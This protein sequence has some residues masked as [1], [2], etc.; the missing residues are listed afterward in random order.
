[1]LIVRAAREL[2]TANGYGAVTI[3]RVADAAGMTPMTLYS[4]FDAK[5]DLLRNLWS[6][7]FGNLFDTLDDV[8]DREPDAQTRLRKVSNGYVRFWVDH[9]DHYRM[10]FM[11]EGVSQPQV[12]VFVNDDEIGA[13]FGLFGRCA[14]ATAHRPT[15]VALQTHLLICSLQGIAHTHVTISGYDWPPPEVLVDALLAA[16]FPPTP[17]NAA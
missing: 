6:D 1:M 12:S 3:R 15:D 11:S 9:P 5:I 7:V 8:A 13:R 17:E 4:Y 16:L 2:F 14:A 10:V